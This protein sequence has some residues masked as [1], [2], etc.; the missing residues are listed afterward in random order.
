MKYLTALSTLFVLGCIA[1]VNGLPDVPAPGI[2]IIYDWPQSELK[3]CAIDTDG[4]DWRCTAST[5]A[6]FGPSVKHIAIYFNGLCSENMGVLIDKQYFNQGPLDIRVDSN[7]VMSKVPQDVHLCLV[8]LRP[9]ETPGPTLLDTEVENFLE[10]SIIKF[11]EL[12]ERNAKDKGSITKDVNDFVTTLK[13]TGGPVGYKTGF[14]LA[15]ADKL[16][17][18]MFPTAYTFQWRSNCDSAAT[19]SGLSTK[20]LVKI[21]KRNDLTPDPT[22]AY[23]DQSCNSG[24]D[25]NGE[26]SS[27]GHDFDDRIYLGA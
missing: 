17:E 22:D 1:N 24:T 7:C 5:Q 16:V 8:V 25:R 21:N 10:P 18:W 15:V 20:I 9:S 14:L 23:P 4:T 11:G 3:I 6:V 19:I 2:T 13:T 26:I 12:Y 27:N